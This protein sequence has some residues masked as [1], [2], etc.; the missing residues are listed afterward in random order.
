VDIDLRDLRTKE[1]DYTDADLEARI[2]PLVD[3]LANAIRQE[4]GDRST[5]VFTPM[6]KSAQGMATALQSIGIRADW[7]S[8][9][10]PDREK[11]IEQYTK[12]E[13]QMLCN[14]QLLTEGV[15]LPRTAAIALCRPTKSRPLYAQIVGRGTR[16]YEGKQDALIIDF[17]FLTT[18]HKLVKHVEL[19][20]GSGVDQEVLD[21]AQE[22]M[23]KN[24]KLSLVDAISE[25]EKEHKRKTVLR[26]QARERNIG[27]KRVSYDPLSVC[28]AIGIPWRG[29]RVTDAVITRATPGQVKLLNRLGIAD[30]PN[31]SR[32]RA[33][34]I[35]DYTLSRSKAGLASP[36][37]TSHLIA[38]GVEPE[39]ARAMS[40][41]EASDFLSKLWG[42]R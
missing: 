39:Q 7:I 15:D 22:L 16:L 30:A 24:K 28:D 35:I 13:I 33:K 34:T 9:D 23:N 21:D 36:K 3:T 37:Q 8:G 40:K 6:I 29:S 27:Y 20:D 1:G 25:A 14:V 26:I 19:C 31:L 32:T 38:N 4:A 12:G 42:K 17:N 5:L 18:K 11:K 2:G 10:D 41:K